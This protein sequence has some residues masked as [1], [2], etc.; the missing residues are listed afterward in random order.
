[1]QDFLDIG[2]DGNDAYVECIGRKNGK[3]GKG[4]NEGF[5]CDWAAYGFLKTLGNGTVVVTPEG[6][7][8][9]VFNFYKEEA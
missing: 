1:V 4:K 5:G 9:D 2:A 7:K 8:E 6:Q 3:G